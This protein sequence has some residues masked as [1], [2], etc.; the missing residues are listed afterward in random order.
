MEQTTERMRAMKPPMVWPTLNVEQQQ[1]VLQTMVSICQQMVMQYQE[2][3][4]DDT[5]KQTEH[6]NEAA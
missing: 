1:Q 4:N 5:G 6:P 3:N 2:E